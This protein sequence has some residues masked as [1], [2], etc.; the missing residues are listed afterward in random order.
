[1]P[2][3]SPS[4]SEA[5]TNLAFEF[6]ALSSAT[7]ELYS[8]GERKREWVKPRQC[9]SSQLRRKC[10]AV[11]WRGQARVCK[12]EAVREQPVEN[13]DERVTSESIR[14][15]LDRSLIPSLS[16]RVRR[17]TNARNSWET[18]LRKIG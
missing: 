17:R 15:R 1:M 14:T 2:R 9:G 4:F 5:F 13:K 18:K 6:P 10:R 11:W 3:I 7:A 8:G 12:A 16:V